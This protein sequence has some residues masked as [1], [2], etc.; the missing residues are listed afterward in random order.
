MKTFQQNNNT[1]QTLTEKIHSKAPT[2][3][4]GA[5]KKTRR[6]TIDKWTMLKMIKANISW[7]LL[8]QQQQVTTNM[9]VYGERFG[10]GERGWIDIGRR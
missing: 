6:L 2:K 7:H 1:L 8:R 4:P 5:R 9:F 10:I 3:R